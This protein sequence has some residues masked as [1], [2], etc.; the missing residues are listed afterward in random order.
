MKQENG[1]H[2]KSINLYSY[3]KI[4]KIDEENNVAHYKKGITYLEEGNTEMAI[5]E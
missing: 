4:L 3:E 5:K 1:K 2:N